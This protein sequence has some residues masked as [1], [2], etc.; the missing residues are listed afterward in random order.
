MFGIGVEYGANLLVN[1]AADHPQLFDGLVSVGNP[2]DLAKA[3]I[4]LQSSWVWRLLYRDVLRGRLRRAEGK[5]ERAASLFEVD[6]LLYGLSD[7]KLLEWKKEQS[8]INAIP[9]LKTRTLFL[10][11]HEDPFSLYLRG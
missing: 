5:G 1:T 7:E 6:K 11:S 4:N 10:Q 3:E 2:F 9:R 8:C